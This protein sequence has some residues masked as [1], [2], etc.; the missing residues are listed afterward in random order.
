[1]HLNP[2]RRCLECNVKTHRRLWKL[3]ICPVCENGT[4]YVESRHGGFVRENQIAALRKE[5][6]IQSGP[7]SGGGKERR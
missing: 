7:R 2:Y 3:E 5:L 4:G 1:M 6:G